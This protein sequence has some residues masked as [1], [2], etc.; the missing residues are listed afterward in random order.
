MCVYLFFYSDQRAIVKKVCV[1]GFVGLQIIK[2]IQ[3]L[4]SVSSALWSQKIKKFLT[5]SHDPRKSHK[6]IFC[7]P[8]VTGNLTQK[9]DMVLREPWYLKSRKLPMK[10][11]H[12]SIHRTYSGVFVLCSSLV[13]LPVMSV[14]REMLSSSRNNKPIIGFTL[15]VQTWL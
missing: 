15:Q 10:Q 1:H 14:T 8:S 6:N 2:K 11:K 5:F 7:L 9:N 13:L 4:F 12:L 3:E